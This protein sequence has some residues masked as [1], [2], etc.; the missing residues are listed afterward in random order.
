MVDEARNVTADGGVDHASVGELEAPDVT[1][2]DVASLAVQALAVRDLLPRVVN[3]P[4]VLRNCLRCEYT[5]PMDL[6]SFPPNHTIK[7][8]RAGLASLDTGSGDP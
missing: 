1:G 4:L 8:A 6:R 5:P 7:I 3:D 2:L